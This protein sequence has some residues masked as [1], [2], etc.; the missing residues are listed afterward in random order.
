MPA[1]PQQCRSL[2]GLNSTNVFSCRSGGQKPG[3]RARQGCFLPRPLPVPLACRWNGAPSWNSAFFLLCL[4]NTR[5]LIISSSQ[6]LCSKHWAPLR[7]SVPFEMHAAFSL[8][9]PASVKHRDLGAMVTLLGPPGAKHVSLLSY[10][11][12]PHHCIMG[13]NCEATSSGGPEARY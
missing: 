9:T 8:D 2:R 7:S 3:A 1:R 6:A 5:H 10:L 4:L 13:R 12:T 11:W